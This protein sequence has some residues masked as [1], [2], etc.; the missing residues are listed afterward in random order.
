[1]ISFLVVEL[2]VD[3]IFNDPFRNTQ[4]MLVPYVLLFLSSTGGMIGIAS[5]AVKIWTI[6]AVILFFNMVALAFFQ[7]AITEM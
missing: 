2:L 6:V 3:Y 1:M 7:Y 4:W 5:Q